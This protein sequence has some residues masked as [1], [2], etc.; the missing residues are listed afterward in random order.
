VRIT[1]AGLPATTVAGGTSYI[2]RQ[3]IKTLKIFFLKS[4]G[5]TKEIPDT[6]NKTEKKKKKKKLTRV[7]TEPAPTVAPRPI[8]IPGL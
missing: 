4:S 2:V 3:I 7:T 5:L 1:R 6:D 8:R